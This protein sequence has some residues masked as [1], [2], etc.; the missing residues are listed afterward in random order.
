MKKLFWT[1]GITLG[2]ALIARGS[3][4]NLSPYVD[5]FTTHDEY[6]VSDNDSVRY[7]D[8]IQLL[9]AK[10]LQATINPVNQTDSLWVLWQVSNDGSI[11]VSA[12][13]SLLLEPSVN[14]AP[15]FEQAAMFR[16]HRIQVGISTTASTSDSLMITWRAG[17]S[18]Y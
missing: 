2:I 4:F 7:S 14:I 5:T 8:T 9:G 3:T 16:Y 11:W 10:K 1:L 17:E 13:D 6:V 18:V 12:G 15:V